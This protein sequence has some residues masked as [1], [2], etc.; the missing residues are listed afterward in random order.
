MKEKHLKGI[1]IKDKD[2]ELLKE[3]F[4][5]DEEGEKE[6]LTEV[7]KEILITLE[8]TK[9][10]KYL[11]EIKTRFTQNE[12][13]KG[14]SNLID[15][16][17]IKELNHPRNK[18]KLYSLTKKGDIITSPILLKVWELKREYKKKVENLIK[19]WIVKV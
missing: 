18:Q 8:N 3:W 9:E 5:N 7:E 11:S 12:R 17:L 6:M 16:Q 4:S 2:M 1:N 13:N 19:E 14:L 10:I 15:K